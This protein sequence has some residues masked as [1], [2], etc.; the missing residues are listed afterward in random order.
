M[1]LRWTE[2][3][4]DYRQKNTIRKI[5]YIGS[6]AA[7]AM[8]FS[9]V[10]A[11][12]PF[13]FGIPGLKLGLA[14]IVTLA[15]LYKFGAGEALLISLIRIFLTGLIFGSGA[16]IIYSLCGGVLSFLI[17]LL[18]VKIKAFSI[19]SVSA[20]GAVFHNIGQLSAACFV[21]KSTAVLSLLPIL[22]VCGI[23]TGVMT[24]IAGERALRLLSHEK[25]I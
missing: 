3:Q 9:Y 13:N 22:T 2:L 10:E 1:R 15:A 6:L 18:L 24:G 12:I 14:N 20:A 19:V 16:S 11:L 23:L 7:T 4:A 21:L 17:M 5:T 25:R 8:I